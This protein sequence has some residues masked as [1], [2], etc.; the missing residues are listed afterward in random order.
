MRILPAPPTLRQASGLLVAGLAHAAGV[1]ALLFY[2]ALPDVRPHAERFPE[3][4]AFMRLRAAEPGGPPIRYQPVPLERIDST[5]VRAVLVSE[6]AA[7]YLHRGVDWHELAQAL[8]EAWTEPGPVRGAS[9][10]T[11]QLARNLYLSP[12]R[13]LGRKLAELFIARRLERDLFKRRILELYLNVI[14]WGPGVYGAQAAARY[15]YDS[16][17]AE[18]TRDRAAR[19]AAVI[20]AP[21]SRSPG[22]MSSYANIIQSRMRALGW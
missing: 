13:S 14:E 22:R 5:L 6:D 2:L 12:E 19:L 10:L 7:F 11:Q 9:T 17:A 18:L 3:T 16:S 21:R 20:P 4:T 8:Q 15:H 1:G